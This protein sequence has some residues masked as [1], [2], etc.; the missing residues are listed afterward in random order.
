[1]EI[2]Q[3][4]T[5][6]LVGTL[7]G[8]INVMAAGGSMITVPVMIFM[9]IPGPVANGTNRIAILAQNIT[10]AFAFF[11]KGYSDFKLSLSLSLCALPGA[12]VGAL[13][14]TR[15]E[16]V[17]FNR[18]LAIIMIIMMVVMSIKQKPVPADQVSAE[19]TRQRLFAG[20]VLMVLAGFYGGFIQIGVGFILLP[21]LHRVL[22]L[23][24][25]RTNM[26]KVFIIASYTIF[27]LAIFITQVEIMW[28]LGICLAIGNSMGGWLGAH[29]SVKKGDAV[30]KM[31]LNVVLVL[32]IIKLLF[33]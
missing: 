29:V 12:I 24:M 1:M 16:G 18:I 15:L 10:A 27:A 21:I 8:F 4:V 11:R 14:G 13:V 19:P 6:I 9:G 30:I 2:W 31:V 17:W 33:F 5:L 32:F 23:D 20:H 26:H 7:A 22:G 28:L 25:V 3:G